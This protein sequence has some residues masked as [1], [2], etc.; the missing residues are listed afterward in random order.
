MSKSINFFSFK[1]K[2]PDDGRDILIIREDR[3]NHCIPVEYGRVDY[4]LEEIDEEGNE[5]GSSAG[6][7]DDFEINKNIPSGYKLAYNLF[8]E[9]MN[10]SLHEEY[11]FYWSYFEEI[12]NLFD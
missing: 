6:L 10:A 3:W 1:E 4:F 2:K 8:S 9:T 5:T 11:D 7:P 12:E